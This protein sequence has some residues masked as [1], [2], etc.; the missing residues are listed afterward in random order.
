M[1]IKF[2]A[3]CKRKKIWGHGN[4]LYCDECRDKIETLRR[5]KYYYAHQEELLKKLS[6][7]RARLKERRL[8]AHEE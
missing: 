7:K 4:K 1:A 3:E 6:E 2:C 8:P 5:R